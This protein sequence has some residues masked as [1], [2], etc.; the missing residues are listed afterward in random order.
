MTVT[1]RKEENMMLDKLLRALTEKI[2][3]PEFPPGGVPVKV[4]A[5]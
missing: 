3:R 5:P 1:E 4:A 2:E